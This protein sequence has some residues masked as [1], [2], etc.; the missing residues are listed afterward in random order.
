MS[1][2]NRAAMFDQHSA[3]LFP[4]TGVHASLDCAS[5]HREEPPFDFAATPT[6]CFACHAE[7]YQQTTRPDHSRVGFSRE[8][9]ECHNTNAWEGVNFPGGA[10]FDHS[11]IFVLTGAHTLTD[12]GSCHLGGRFA[13]TPRDC[14][15]CH[16]VDFR[17]S[18]DPDHAGAGFPTEC[19]QCHETVSWEGAQFDHKTFFRLTGAHRTA[20]CVSCHADGVYAGTPRD[21]FSCHSSEFQQ[22]AN[23]DHVAAGFG[24][25]CE[26]CHNAKGWEGASFDHNQ[27]FRLTGAHK[28]TEC[29]SCHQNGQYEGTPRDCYSC[30]RSDYDGT[31]DPNHA[32]AGFPTDC[33]GC[34]NAKGW[35]GAT[36][37]HDRVFR[38]TGAHKTVECESCHQDG[39]YEGTPRDCYS[40]HRSDYDGT[41]DPSH[42]AAG[43]PT[44][45]ETCHNTSGWEGATFDHDQFF[46]LTGAHRAVECE[47]CHQDGQYEGT[48]RDCYSCHRSDYDGTRDPNHSAAGFPTAC[49]T[50]HN[51]SGWEGA[52]FDHDLY[53]PIDRGAH[54]NLECSDCHV[55]S[56]SFQIFECTSCH[57]HS[58]QEMDEEHDDVAGYVWESNACYSCHPDGRED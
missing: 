45:C 3:T 55:V 4:L 48:P 8:C 42:S 44:A 40:C 50:C 46:R 31:T 15:S 9:Q 23:P 34:H 2:D 51:T 10:D 54:R 6:E 58:R 27:F 28:K 38:L 39:Q 21:C 5:C 17:N 49:E 22:A 20:E 53:F 32:T 19:E 56:S 14:F 25:D 30:H 16:D 37:D 33:K 43:F 1:W 18:R 57:E 7:D 26:G 29:E 11:A 12:C 13:G 41:N 47:S 52:T 24:T 35:E 36:F